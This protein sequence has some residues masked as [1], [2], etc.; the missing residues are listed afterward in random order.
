MNALQCQLRCEIHAVA[1]SRGF[2]FD[3]VRFASLRVGFMMVEAWGGLR[4]AILHILFKDL[5]DSAKRMNFIGALCE[6]IISK[7]EVMTKV[8]IIHRRKE[9]R[10][11]HY[12]WS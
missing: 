6:Q 10:L 4:V 8:D 9:G 3:D 1:G 12:L 5:L 7:D 11:L 2:H